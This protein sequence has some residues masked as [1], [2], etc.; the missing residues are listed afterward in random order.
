MRQRPFCFYD[1]QFLYGCQGE[2]GHPFMSCL[3]LALLSTIRP[4][5]TFYSY[6]MIVPALLQNGG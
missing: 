1:T 3:L 4:F 5:T 6:A 2:K